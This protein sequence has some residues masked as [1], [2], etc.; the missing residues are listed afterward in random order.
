MGEQVFESMHNVSHQVAI[1]AAPILVTRAC[2]PT[3]EAHY[4]VF[5]DSCGTATLQDFI[6]ECY[7]FHDHLK[8]MWV[9]VQQSAVSAEASKAALLFLVEKV[10]W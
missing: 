10:S 1:L 4:C 6:P 3:N 7:L 5:A 8:N 9:L 2:L